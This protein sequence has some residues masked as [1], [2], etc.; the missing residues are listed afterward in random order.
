MT[1]KSD[2][3]IDWANALRDAADHIE[4]GE[5]IRAW[6]RI[7]WVERKLNEVLENGN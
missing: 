6:G 4:D 1:M 5:L 7:W 3:L 2:N